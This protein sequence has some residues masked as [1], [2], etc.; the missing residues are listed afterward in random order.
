MQGTSTQGWSAALVW[1]ANLT[2]AMFE[3]GPVYGVAGPG[4]SWQVGV[5]CLRYKVSPRMYES[6]CSFQ[7]SGHKSHEGSHTDEKQA[8]SEKA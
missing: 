5:G 6:H 7:R 4:R 8:T 2:A 3:V 1:R